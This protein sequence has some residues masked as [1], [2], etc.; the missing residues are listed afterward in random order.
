MQ[1]RVC[2]ICDT[3]LPWMTKRSVLK[4]FGEEECFVGCYGWEG[5]MSRERLDRGK[6]VVVG[7]VKTRG[8]GQRA[9]T[10]MDQERNRWDDDARL[11]RED[12]FIPRIRSRPNSVRWSE[13][14]SDYKQRASHPIVWKNDRFLVRT[15]AKRTFWS[16]DVSE[17][18][19][20]HSTLR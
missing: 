7:K 14:D 12:R 6:R 1:E 4:D 15:G 16:R 17:L 19:W 5:L 10:G 2:G 8:R 13:V 20:F 18:N 3:I 11:T 9:G